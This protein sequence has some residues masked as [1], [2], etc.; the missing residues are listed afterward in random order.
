MEIKDG[1]DL[2]KKVGLAYFAT[3]DG[4]NPCVRMMAIIHHNDE[5]WATTIKGRDKIRQIKINNKFEFSGFVSISENERRQIRAR[6]TVE[7]IPDIEIK[8]KVID[9]ISFF[10]AYWNSPEDPRFV[11][12]KLHIES[13]IIQEP[14]ETPGYPIFHRFDLKKLATSS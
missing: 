4:D 12:L 13:I 11:L 2:L 10:D 7:I 5:V 1:I 3:V 8:R 14:T 9:S 6:G